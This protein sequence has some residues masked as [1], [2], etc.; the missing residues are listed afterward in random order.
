[1]HNFSDRQVEFET[2]DRI[3][4]IVFQ[5]VEPPTFVEVF[6]FRDCVTKRNE[7]GFGSTE[8]REQNEFYK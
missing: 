4:Q 3:A 5:K 1:M 7:Q 6:D 2:G 8:V